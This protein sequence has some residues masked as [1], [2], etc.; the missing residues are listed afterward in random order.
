MF[1]VRVTSGFCCFCDILLYRED[2]CPHFCSQSLLQSAEEFLIFPHDLQTFQVGTRNLSVY[3]KF[4]HKWH[5]PVEVHSNTLPAHHTLSQ[6]HRSIPVCCS[7]HGSAMV[8]LSS[9][10]HNAELTLLHP[11]QQASV[12]FVLSTNQV[13]DLD[14]A[15]Q[16]LCPYPC[17]SAF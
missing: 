15:L 5:I 3:L 8:K 17:S 7:I 6:R 13:C 14:L 4:H 10:Q 9:R 16:F 2:R 11:I 12:F 1:L